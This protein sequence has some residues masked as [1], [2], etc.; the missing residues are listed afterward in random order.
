[1]KVT[2]TLR[3]FL[4]L[5]LVQ[6]SAVTGAQELGNI[7]FP[8]SGSEAAQTDFLTGVKALHSFQFDEAR[9]AFERAQKTDPS[10]A[11]AYWGQ[12]MSDNHPLWAQQDIDA[13]SVALNRLAPNYDAR[14]KAAKTE[15]EKEFIAAVET[16]YFS[17]GDKLQRDF[18]YSEHMARMHD[19]WPDDDEISIFYALS[20][21][22]TVRPGDQGYRRQA[23]AA[24]ISQ[25]VFARNEQHPGA[26]HFIIH[27]FDD[28][29]HAILALP[30]ATV[31]AEIAPAAAHA[32][33]MPSHI[34]L[35]LGMWQD[36]VNS[37]ID[38]YDAAVT[39]N[40]KFGLAEGRE[41]FHTLSWL[42][43][44]NLM[45][46][47]F[48]DASENLAQARATLDRNAD[49]A[50]VRNGYLNMRGRHVLETGQWE[51][52]ELAAADTPEGS[53]ANWVSVVG[54][55]A[56]YLGNSEKAQLATAR[57]GMLKERM[58]TAGRAYDAKKISVL[59][60]E[61]VAVMS[62]MNGDEQRAIDAARLAADIEIREMQAPSGPPD[63]MKPAIE[64][65]ADIL[66]ATNRP[67]EALVA[68][69]QSLQWI[70][71]RA[72]SV[73]GLE[74]AASDAGQASGG[75]QNPS[76]AD[77]IGPGGS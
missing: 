47:N 21:L 7:A 73:M 70:P 22:G 30:A 24:S 5:F 66:L 8:N 37:N 19:R 40:K 51:D 49:S 58:E 67:V 41:D 61:V 16:L 68:Y 12:A 39:V 57:L 56:A 14:L 36:V 69:E 59:E 35:Q 62:L 34:F 52:F 72:P 29:D 45:L 38:A 48:D 15:K 54:M 65:Y 20:L 9:F 74:K 11:L 13:A 2:T 1:M 3:L 32:L 50:M 10:F 17:P 75:H 60:N 63:P 6:A 71:R 43:Y 4:A 18:A 31:Y 26:A 64:L 42:A 27:S 28:P 77:A 55:S 44:A 76:I 23:L 25:S 46:G 53:H 33:H